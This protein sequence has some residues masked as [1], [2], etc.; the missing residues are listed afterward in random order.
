M[1]FRR[2]FSIVFVVA[3]IVILFTFPWYYEYLTGSRYRGLEAD[4]SMTV[5]RFRLRDL[6]GKEVRAEDLRGKYSY[7]FLGFSKCT[8]ICPR[9][10]GELYTFARRAR[11]S[12]AVDFRIVFISI[13]PVRDRP[14]QLQRFFSGFGKRFLVLRDG[15]DKVGRVARRFGVYYSMPREA[16]VG[17]DYQINHPELV[18]VLDRNA[19]PRLLYTRVR[20]EDLLKD[21]DVLRGADEQK[22]NIK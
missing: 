2:V 14:A 8:G 16:A 6:N 19:R 12:P 21:W 18:Y 10:L 5:P 15:T 11:S 7:V 1:K 4:S 13:D 20:A 22:L 3:A 9:A 17:G